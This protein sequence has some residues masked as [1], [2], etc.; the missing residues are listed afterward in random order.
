MHIKL[1]YHVEF[2]LHVLVMFNHFSVNVWIRSSRKSLVQL[3]RG[4]GLC[5]QFYHNSRKRNTCFCI[6]SAVYNF[7]YIVPAS[8]NYSHPWTHTT[9][10]QG[11]MIARPYNIP[12]STTEWKATMYIHSVVVIFFGCNAMNEIQM[13]FIDNQRCQNCS[14]MFANEKNMF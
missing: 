8:Q 14:S 3:L 12:K 6:I 2:Q 1:D 10:D 9:R 11:S 5:M 13:F 4:C 7:T